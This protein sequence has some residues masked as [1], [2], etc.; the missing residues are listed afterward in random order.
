MDHAGLAQE[1]QPSILSE[2]VARVTF[3][4]DQGWVSRELSGLWVAG[5]TGAEPARGSSAGA[6]LWV[7]HDED[8]AARLGAR[9]VRL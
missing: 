9:E 3:R 7:S 1:R 6:V 4:L 2:V 8:L 5:S